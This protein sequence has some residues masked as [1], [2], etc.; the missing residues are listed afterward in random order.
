M[1]PYCRHS[2]EPPG[3]PGSPNFDPPATAAAA[4]AVAT[5]TT[6]RSP[7]A[8]DG[9]TPPL[10]M[11]EPDFPVVVLS[12]AVDGLPGGGGRTAADEVKS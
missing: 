10:P 2:P 8:A 6:D 9:T 7:F 5:M 12:T 3:R 1:R 4:A 11:T